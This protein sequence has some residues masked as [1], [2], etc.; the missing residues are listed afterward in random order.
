M[1]QVTFEIFIAA[2]NE[3]SKFASQ[4]SNPSP[5]T[6][7]I[8]QGGVTTNT[9][10]EPQQV[11]NEIAGN[12]EKT[13]SHLGGLQVDDGGRQSSDNTGRVDGRSRRLD[14]SSIWELVVISGHVTSMS[15][16]LELTA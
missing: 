3:C 14:R 6:F 8:D 12:D 13:H 11:D 7:S 4:R 15:V 1:R 10:S 2:S 16:Q 9:D 5:L